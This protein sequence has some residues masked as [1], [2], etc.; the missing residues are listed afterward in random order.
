MDILERKKYKK[1][2]S[3][4][5][6]DLKRDLIGPEHSKEDII[7]EGPSQAYITGIL[8]P[9]ESEV[10]VEAYLEEQFEE[11]DANSERQ[12]DEEYSGEYRQE[13]EI[14]AEKVV[15]NDKKFRNQNSMG[16]KF[17]LNKN[18][19]HVFVKSVWGKY[20]ASKRLDIEKEKEITVWTRNIQQVDIKIEMD[21]FEY[22]KEIE[23]A[24]DV[25]LLINKK[26]LRF[27][28]NLMCSIFLTNKS[29][30]KNNNNAMFQCQLVLQHIEGEKIF[31]CESEA[32]DKD[33]FE[34]FLYRNKPV[35]AKGFGCAVDWHNSDTKYAAEIRS[36][37]IPKH[38]VE[39]VS[40]DLP[41]DS[42]Y[43]S[44]PRN[45][46]SIKEFAEVKDKREAIEKLMNLAN[47][48]EN[49][50]D[51]LSTEGIDEV[52]LANKSISECRIALSRI[53][54]GIDIL[55]NVKDDRAFLA[56]KFM[57]KVMHT[58]IAMKKYA[59]NREQSTL[60]LEIKKDSLNWRPFQLAFIL[61]NIEGLVDATSKDREIVDLLWF[62]TGGGK[63]EAYLGIAAFLLG[64]RRLT[65]SAEDE[66]ERDGGVTILLRYTLRLLTTQQRDRLM[67][68]ICACE[69]IRQQNTIF[70]KSEFSV[71]FWV[72]GQVTANKLEELSE[73]KFRTDEKV[74]YAYKKIKKQIIECPCCGSKDLRFKFLP[75][76]NTKTK[77]TGVKIYCNKE[78][79]FFF[80]NHIPVYLVDE[81]IYRKLPTVII[82]TVDK[83]A[84]L[85]WDEKTASLFGK[86]N[87]LCEK[88]GYITEGE[89]HESSHRNPKAD[90]HKVKPFY[91]P[92][93]IIQDELHL[94]TGPLGTIY[95]G[96]ETIVE[97]LSIAKG[98]GIRLCPKYIAATATIKNAA[99]QVE[100]I[101]GRSSTQQFPP[102][103]LEIEDS[104]FARELSLDEFP[105][106]L[107]TGI[108]VSGNSMKTVL[109]RVYAVL[110]QT[111]ENLLDDED[112]CK[113]I[114]PYRTLI[115]Y[116]NSVRELGGAVR[117]LDDDIKK[118]IQTLKKK[119]HYAKQRYINRKPELTSRVPSSQIP[120]V[121]EQ[122]E[123]TVGNEELDVVLATNMISVGM[124]VD[125]L[126]LMVVT[127]QPKQTSEYIQASSRVG[128]SKPGL[129][130]TV[131]NPYRPRDMS[132]YQS[133]KGYHQRLYHFVEGTTATPYASRA[134]DRVLHAIAVS[135]LRLTDTRMAKNEDAINIKDIDLS[136]L[137][138]VIKKRVGI[139][140][141]GNSIDTMQDLEKFLDEWINYST[142]EDNLQYYFHPKNKKARVGNNTRILARFTEDKECRGRATLDSMRQ[143]EGTS[144]LYIYEGWNNGEK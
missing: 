20:T 135:L 11:L 3:I 99:M 118:R 65:A 4:L 98:N 50:I 110:L 23:I 134:R 68:M 47:R 140:E 137:R 16:M 127:G 87:R 95:G 78:V 116:F 73:S 18:T 144:S 62:P 88:C 66:Y 19:D 109:L 138:E 104:F 51:R 69:Y 48:Y 113:Y 29:V 132:H 126:G 59:K 94:I 117:L 102:S 108:C 44:L 83:F 36:E 141:P 12:V 30:D 96:Y 8:Y 61:L 84:R 119:Y 133:F 41:F 38:E 55:N 107:Y 40:T 131:Y 67:R 124:D 91:P 85:P 92:E 143:V 64:Y 142:S 136:Y 7:Y 49:W 34:E 74:T 86:V 25:F 90:V 33:N 15:P 2:R 106:R 17:Y 82:S 52:E 14:E 37:F 9:L 54:K 103:G 93:L 53:R 80:K 26:K 81:D 28:D 75:N 10:E 76:E 63:T 105:F 45:Y 5:I 43:G 97:E 60:E 129:V 22:K 35:F 24:K 57:N 121:L 71:G 128:R 120:R 77:K 125:R 1:I 123:R 139:V 6:E 111:T 112:L 115:G 42:E 27:T 101:F 114:D 100:K 21:S 130:V 31:L 32:R 70:G 122:L 46:F 89:K 72:G 56:F 58:Q 13:H 79:C 39:S